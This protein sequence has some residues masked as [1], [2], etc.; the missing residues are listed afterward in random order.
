MRATTGLMWAVLFLVTGSAVNGQ[1]LSFTPQLS[2][3]PDFFEHGFTYCN[4]RPNAIMP[5]KIVREIAVRQGINPI[6]YPNLMEYVSEK[7]RGSF[8][9]W[10]TR[11]LKWAGWG[12][13]FVLNLDRENS[14]GNH[15]G[16]IIINSRV[17]ALV[18]AGAVLMT[19]VESEVNN[20]KKDLKIPEDALRPD[21]VIGPFACAEL[22]IWEVPKPK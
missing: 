19:Y 1:E 4:D 13:S 7:N 20:E 11:G 9:S 18:P 14:E 17:K 16:P 15:T 5:N 2:R 6:T 22:A 21:S 3:L 8:F 12:F 10:L